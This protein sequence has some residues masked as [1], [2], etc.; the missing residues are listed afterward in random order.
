MQLESQ[1]RLDQTSGQ[2]RTVGCV[3]PNPDI[4]IHLHL[5]DL[6]TF[7]TPPHPCLLFNQ[8]KRPNPRP[9]MSV[10]LETSL[11][12]L[13]IDLE[14]DKCPKTCENFLKLCK[15]KYYNLNAFFNGKSLL[16]TLLSARP[17]AV[18]RSLQIDTIQ[19]PGHGL[20]LT[21][22]V[23][24]LHLS[25]RRPHRLRNRRRVFRLVQHL[26][27]HFLL[28]SLYFPLPLLCPRHPSDPKAHRPRNSLHGR[29]PLSSPGRRF[30]IL[31]H[32]R[33]LPRLSGR[34]PSLC[35]WTRH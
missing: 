12:E 30:S 25:D 1:A 20:W 15:V 8:H 7:S 29:L 6:S 22:S 13:V 32:P 17:N 16:P 11:G 26:P 4:Q 31:H 23:Q 18:R 21:T 19:S 10:M 2:P 5:L 35:L 3:H 27:P 9:S 28:Y 33:T 24:E 34:A 14:V